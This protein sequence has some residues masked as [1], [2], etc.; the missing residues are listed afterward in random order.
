MTRQHFEGL[1]KLVQH[2]IRQIE[3]GV[4]VGPT[5]IAYDL[6]IFCK[7][8]NPGFDHERFILACQPTK[9]GK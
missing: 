2:W 9:E 5:V 4:P 6:A 8:Y 3:S 1:A 7:S